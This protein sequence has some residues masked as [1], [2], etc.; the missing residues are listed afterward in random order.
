[1][2]L[3]FTHKRLGKLPSDV[4]LPEIDAPLVSAF[5]AHLEK[6]RRN[7]ARTRNARLAAI[8]S[9]FRFVSL[10]EPSHLATCQRVLAIPTK[11]MA[12]RLVT[13]LSRAEIDAILAAPDRSTW[14]GRRDHALLLLALQTGLRVLSSSA[15]AAPTSC[16]PP[17]RTSV[18]AVRVAKTAARH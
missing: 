4:L 18:A 12:R 10:E 1:L 15:S 16:S 2:L 8:H 3:Q 6:E 7:T 11:R 14:L 9:F 17:V 5:L 13:S